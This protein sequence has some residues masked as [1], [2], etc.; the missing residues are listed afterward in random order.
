MGCKVQCNSLRSGFKL[1]QDF[2]SHHAA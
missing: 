2:S 1:T